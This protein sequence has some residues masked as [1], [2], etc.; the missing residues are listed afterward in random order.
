MVW[1]TKSSSMAPRVPTTFSVKKGETITVSN[2][3]SASQTF[4]I[5]DK[6]IDVVRNQGQSQNVTINL[7]PGAYQF[8][9][10]FHVNL[11]MK[12]TLTVTG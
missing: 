5:A 11:G 4:T 8:I 1:A 3:G 2:V 7:A 9:C 10:R 12:G 6:G